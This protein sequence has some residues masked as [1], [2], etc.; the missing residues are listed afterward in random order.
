MK[1]ALI[2]PQYYR[3]LLTELF[4]FIKQPTNSISSRR[5]QGEKIRDT[6]GFFILKLMLAIPVVLF[7]ALVYDPADVQ[8]ANMAKRFSPL[9][10]LLVG[11]FIL[12]LLEEVT[13]RLSL[14]FRPVFLALSSSGLVY[15][16]ITKAIFETKASAVDDS[17]LIRIGSSLA[18]G[19]VV[20]LLLNLKT[21]G[22]R[23]S[24]FWTSHF[25]LIYYTICIV[26]GWM[27]IVKYEL[28]WLNILLLPILTLP[29]LTSAFIYGYVRVAF[30]FKYPLMLHMTTNTLA[31][32][33]S[34]LPGGDILFF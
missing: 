4:Q 21:I 31:I 14:V 29:Q 16:F 19:L 23:V 32:S 10:L 8:G 6:V 24:A 7:F 28:I 13:F 3:S 22:E 30:G 1:Y 33:L 34:F 5:S 26:F 27:H 25:R 2:R 12:P 20:F 18:V 11:G 15:Y 17:F 9:V